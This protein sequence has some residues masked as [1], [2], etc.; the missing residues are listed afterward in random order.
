VTSGYTSRVKALLENVEYTIDHM[1]QKDV[2]GDT[3]VHTSLSHGMLE[4]AGLLL[5][6]THFDFGE[7]LHQLEDARND[8]MLAALVRYT[9]VPDGTP[10]STGDLYFGVAESSKICCRQQI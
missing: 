7:L 9:N 2:G 3:A 5:F 4:C 10:V 6:S 1:A 8:N